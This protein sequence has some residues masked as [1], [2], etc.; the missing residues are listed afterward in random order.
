MINGDGLPNSLNEPEGS[1]SAVTVCFI[2]ML[3]WGLKKLKQNCESSSY[4][5]VNLLSCMTLFVE[6]LHSAV[7]R[8]RGTETLV[9]YAQDFAKIIKEF[10]KAVAKWSV[11]Y[12]TIRERWYPLPDSAVYLAS[13]QFP[14]RTKNLSGK[15]LNSDQKCEMQEWVSVNGAV[16]R[17]RSYRQEPT[18]ARAGTLPGNA[19]FEALTPISS[20]QGTNTNE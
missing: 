11:L 16:V 10:I 17:Q 13:L 1:V 15:M 2:K 12:F 18:M 3:L 20:N 6:N 4:K 7:N 5:E 9:S 14:K 19:Y 8:K